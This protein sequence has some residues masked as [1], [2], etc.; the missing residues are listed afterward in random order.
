MKLPSLDYLLTSA[1]NSLRRF[2]LTIIS[3]FI[4]VSFGIF[5]IEYGEDMANMLPYLNFMLCMSLGIPLFFCATIISNKQSFDKKGNFIMNLFATGILVIIYF[6]LPNSES[7]HNTSLPYVKYAIY[8]ITCHLLVSFIPFVFSKQ[9]NAFWHYNKI[10][11]IRILTSILYSGFIY[12]GLIIALTSLKQLFD[13]DIHEK[14]YLELWVITICFFNTWFFVSG[15][16]LNF[17]DLEEIDEYPKGLK[18]F[19]Q[20]VL[21]PLLTLYLIILYTY[22]TKILILWDWPRG[23]VSYL[24]IGMSVLGILAFLLI[25]P[26]G[27]LKDNSWIKKATKWYYLILFPLLVILFLAIYMRINDYGIT[28]NR[29]IVL[30][31]AIWLAI[32]CLYT[33]LGKT[34][35]KFIPSSLAALLIL[36]SFGPW[37]MFSLSER[38]QVNRLKNILEQSKI[39]VGNKVENETIWLKDSF[40]NIYSVNELKNEG[41]LTDSMHNEVKSILDYLDSHHGF[42]SI[43]E[44][45]AQNIDSIISLNNSKKEKS[46]KNNEAEIYMKTMG[47]KYEFIFDETNIRSTT[48]KSDHNSS[49]TSISGYDYLVDFDKY[50]YEESDQELCRFTL[51]SVEYHITFMNKPNIKMF[52][53]CK[54]DTLYLDIN[55][56]VNNLKKEYGKTPDSPLPISKMQLNFSMN[57]FEFKMDYH[58]IEIN[59]K[60]NIHTINNLTGNIFIRKK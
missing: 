51:D 55:N 53:V 35:I 42:S 58:A 40:P 11:F 39:L 9:L 48:F 16:P 25:H 3:S 36:I 30:V 50:Y 8:N 24:I 10:L 49:I 60:K 45:Y 1:N 26:Y 57:Q 28:I 2:P 29:Y 47:L 12:I 37:G 6:T 41:R 14:L 20:F 13:I 46:A 4:A 22:G 15:I 54:N 18:I 21:L 27:N 34:N 31:I 7:T 33:A 52:L 32:V 44:W 23:I 17:D 43:R 19:T 38:S 56:L 59:L 5:L